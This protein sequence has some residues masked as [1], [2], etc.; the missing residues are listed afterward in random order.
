V[1]GKE[2][3]CEDVESYIEGWRVKETGKARGYA[4]E[5]VGKGGKSK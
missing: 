4:F 1:A 5:A 3:G 2:N